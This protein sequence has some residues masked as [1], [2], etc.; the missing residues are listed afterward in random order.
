MRGLI[1]VMAWVPAQVLV[2]AELAPQTIGK[3]EAL[4]Q[5]EMGRQRIPGL[6]VA[7]AIGGELAWARGFGLADVENQVPATEHTVYRLA[8]LSKPITAVAALQLAERGRLD[9]DAPVQRYVPAFPS[10]PWP[11]TPR[12][13]LGHLAGIRHYRSPEELNSTTHHTSLQSA[14]AIFQDDPLVARPGTQFVYSTYGYVLLGAVIEAAARQPFFDYVRS[15]VLAPVGITTIQ[16]D[17]I[18]RIIPRRARGYRLNRDGELENCALADTSNKI[19][20]GGLVGTAPDMVRFALAVRDGRLLRPET[21][22]QMWTPQRLANGRRTHYGLGWALGEWKGEQVVGH[23]GGQQGVSTALFMLPGRGLVIAVMANLEKA[24]LGPVV[25]GVL[26]LLA[27][28]E[29]RP[30]R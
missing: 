28:A 1:L 20:G 13:L 30:A 24:S 26:Q 8:S 15:H 27:G 23:T 7:V 9:L 14:L 17:D 5:H 6:T 11:I 21:V 25:T 4:V 29:G 22:R 12:L 10:K 2:A 19:P 3:I 16:A 18:Y